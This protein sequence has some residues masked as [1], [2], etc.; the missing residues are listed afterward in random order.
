MYLGHGREQLQKGYVVLVCAVLLS[1]FSKHACGQDRPFE[2]HDSV[3]MTIFNDPSQF[4][5]APKVKQSPDGKYVLLV[6]SRG[7][8]ESDQIQSTLWL[9]DVVKVRSFLREDKPLHSVVPRRLI[10]IAAEPASHGLDSYGSIITDARWSKRSDL[11]YFRAQNELGNHQ[12]YMMDIK[13]KKP[14]VL[15]PADCDVQSFDV[16]DNDTLIYR[17]SRLQ[18]GGDDARPGERINHD[19]WEVTGITLDNILFPQIR[20][21]ETRPRITELW[22][23]SGGV[24]HPVFRDSSAGSQEDLNAI[25]LLSISP[26][27]RWAVQLRPVSRVPISWVRY[28]PSSAY[29]YL[30]IDPSNAAITSPYNEFRLKQYELIDLERRTTMWVVDAPQADP[31]GYGPL[32]RAIWSASG[33]RL[34]LLNTYFPFMS[35]DLSNRDYSSAPCAVVDIEL[36]ST[37]FHCISIETDNNATELPDQ[38]QLDTAEFGAN[39]E[40][41]RVTY[42]GARGDLVKMFRLKGSE[43]NPEEPSVKKDAVRPGSSRI[44]SSVDESVDFTIKQSWNDSPVLW[45]SDVSSGHGRALWNPNPQLADL[46]LGQAQLFQWTSDDGHPWKGILIRPVGFTPSKRYPLVIQT[47][48]FREDQFMTATDGAFPTGMAARA[49]ASAGIMVLQMPSIHDG[50]GSTKEALLNAEGFRS[51]AEHLASEGLV[52]STRVGIVGFSRTCWYVETALIKY[53]K[54]F[55][56]ATITDGIDQSYIQYHLLSEDPIYS[57]Q[58]EHMYGAKPFGEGLHPWLASAS[59]FHLDKVATPLRIEAIGP[60]SVLLE[61]EIYSS[62]REQGKPVELAYIPQGYHVLQRPLDRLASGEGAV[63][64]FRFWLQDNEDPNKTKLAQYRRWREMK[65]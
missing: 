5:P 8:I 40:E 37:E 62:L 41:V 16:A 32:E 23:I 50:E 55:A 51:A 3:G 17:F 42:R 60:M 9:Y 22:A 39:D 4:T 19:A 54:L 31:L 57:S 25:D 11:I 6:T 12:I 63:D 14:E 44:L 7:L 53:P 61:W 58:I 1:L 47:H 10:T 43:W 27:G 34:L 28:Q 33:K 24:S 46:E 52:D 2:V 29:K 38:L 48:G 45:A 65:K 49:L 20:R 26:D 35:R 15:T 59:G 30:T 13:G 18:H 56:A 36:V 21:D 64:W